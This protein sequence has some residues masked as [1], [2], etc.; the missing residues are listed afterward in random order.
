MA[1]SDDYHGQPDSD[2]DT[3]A[4]SCAAQIMN[5]DARHIFCYGVTFDGP[6][7]TMWRFT[8]SISLKST[9]FDMTQ[10]PDLLIRLLTSLLYS[11]ASDLGHDP[12]ITLLPDFNY[13][14]E[15]PSASC[16][17]SLYYKTVAPISDSAPRLVS[18]RRLRI[19]EV[20]QVE[21]ASNPVPIPGKSNRVLKDVFLDHTM[22]TEA[23]IQE[24]LFED[25]TKLA[26]DVNWRSRPL[27]QCCEER[28]LNQTKDQ[29][30]TGDGD[31][32][33]SLRELM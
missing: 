7:V 3:L 1:I 10:R 6:E 27:L 26:E 19:W 21:S 13:V 8:R 11:P 17:G 2:E 33:F 15:I 30:L 22:R 24:E 28:T 4:L 25:I 18:G 23:D 32:A 12:L 29:R 20:Q 16:T 9:P 31:S 5:S 14:Y